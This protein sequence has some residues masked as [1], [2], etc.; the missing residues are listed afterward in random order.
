LKRFR[1]RS[2]I[3]ESIS[4]VPS[5]ECTLP[6]RSFTARQSPSEVNTEQGMVTVLLKM[7]VVRHSLLPAVRRILGGVQIDD[8]PAFGFLPEKCIDR[9]LQCLVECHRPLR[10]SE[11]LVFKP[12]EH[13]LA[14]R[15]FIILAQ[16]QTQCG[17]DPEV[18]GVIAVFI[19]GCHLV[20]TLTDQV[21]LGVSQRGCPPRIV[22][23]IS[24]GSRDVEPFVD[25]PQHQ[26]T[27]IRADLGSPEIDTNGPVETRKN[28]I[29]FPLTMLV[30]P[31]ASPKCHVFVIIS[32]AWLGF[33]RFSLH[34]SGIIQ[35]NPLS[36]PQDQDLRESPLPHCGRVVSQ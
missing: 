32:G 33:Q 25:F 36:D 26:N 19:P 31:N 6:S 28:S 4:R 23:A 14:R 9:S 7:T 29:S 1:C 10:V 17:I 12:G 16:G 11:D 30:L 13:R 8:E 5:A 24:K 34:Y 35:V 18:I 22:H 15:I 20:D 3:G 27:C 21:H 2:T